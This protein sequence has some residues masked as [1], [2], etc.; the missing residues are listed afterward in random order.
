[1][2]DLLL[3]PLTD[4]RVRGCRIFANWRRKLWRKTTASLSDSRYKTIIWR[5][6][7]GELYWKCSRERSV[8][9]IITPCEQR[10]I[11]ITG[12]RVSNFCAPAGFHPGVRSVT[13]KKI[14]GRLEKKMTRTCN[15]S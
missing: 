9:K 8:V 2:G 13:K 4:P 6:M 7:T 3:L 10:V 14:I 11:Q 1:M 15:L 12:C 5:T